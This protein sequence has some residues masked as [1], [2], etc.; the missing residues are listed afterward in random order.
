MPYKGQNRLFEKQHMA[1]K[2]ALKI[3]P[4]QIVQNIHL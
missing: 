1:I 3:F 4:Y 2:G